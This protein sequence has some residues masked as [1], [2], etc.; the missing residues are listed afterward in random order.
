MRTEV[1]IA[2]EGRDPPVRPHQ[3]ARTLTLRELDQPIK[4]RARKLP[5][6]R[7]DP[8]H[9]AA[10]I[11]HAPKHLELGFF[12]RFAKVLDLEPVRRRIEEGVSTRDLRIVDEQP[13][14]V[15]P[16]ERESCG[17]SDLPPSFH[18][19]QNRE[20][21]VFGHQDRILPMRWCQNLHQP[22]RPGWSLPPSRAIPS[23]SVWV[24]WPNFRCVQTITASLP[25]K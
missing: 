7:V 15:A 4:F 9:H 22:Y 13:R 12:E 23:R 25:A 24:G 16:S 2:N 14:V 5:G 20:E 17:N 3:S 6:T 18:A 10:A 8:P 19:V 21:S 1:R 11:E